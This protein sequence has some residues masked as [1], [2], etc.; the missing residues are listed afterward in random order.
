MKTGWRVRQSCPS[1][2]LTPYYERNGITIYNGDCQDVLPTLG[3]IDLVVT[4][5]PY[6]ISYH[7]NHYV[8]DNPFDP[9]EGDDRFP[10]VVV[11]W[12]ITHAQAGALVFMPVEALSL[13]PAAKSHI[14]WVKN[15]W[16]AG[17][18][19]HGYAHMWELAAFWPGPSHQFA[20]GR[21]QDVVVSPR[22]ASTSMQHPTEKPVELLKKLLLHHDCH[23]VLDPYMGSG[24]TLRAAKDLGI[25]ATGIE[26]N[27][28]YCRATVARLQQEVL[29]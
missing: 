1:N 26:I 23:H 6:G 11:N 27:E 21:P 20:Q 24:S 5:P 19:E 14:A 8:G 25:A 22:V 2:L 3:D 29:F 18:L 4:D 7:S 13:L 10:N 15:N 12:C 28:S 16:T 9:I 17:D